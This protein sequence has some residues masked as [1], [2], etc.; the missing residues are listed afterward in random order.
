MNLNF[1]TNPDPN[2][3]E[4]MRFFA[5]YF[6][7]VNKYL[8][9]LPN[10]PFDNPYS[11]LDKIIFQ[12]ENNPKYFQNYIGNYFQQFFSFHDTK[13][14]KPE[15]SVI[16][17]LHRQYNLL[18]YKKKK[19]WVNDNSDFIDEIKRLHFEYKTKLFDENFSSLFSFINCSHTLI[20]HISEIKFSVQILV[21]Q[22]RLNGYSKQ[23]VD[24]SIDRILSRDNFPF[25]PHIV[26]IKN[27]SQQKKAQKE[28][29]EKRNFKEQF[30][31]LKNLLTRPQ[32]QNGIFIYAIENCSLDSEINDSFKIIFD[33]VTFISPTHNLLK[34][35]NQSILKNPNSLTE[36]INKFFFGKNILLAYI[37]LNYDV[38]KYAE[39]IGLKVVKQELRQFNNYLN[40]DLKVNTKHFLFTNHLNKLEAANISL[41]DG[42]KHIRENDVRILESNPYETLRD[43]LS[44]AKSQ[45]LYNEDIF[46]RAIETDDV[47]FYWHYIENT[48]WSINITDPLKI[49]EEFSKLLFKQIGKLKKEVLSAMNSLIIPPFGFDYKEIGLEEDD[50][51]IPAGG[52]LKRMNPNFNIL[53]FEHKIK[54]PFLSYLITYHKEF[55]SIDRNKSWN[56]YFKSLVLE[57][58]EYRNNKVHSGKV[59]LFAEI[60]LREALPLVMNKVRWDLINACKANPNLSF[61]E[62]IDL[63]TQ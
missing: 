1:L 30:F 16:E 3:Q 28:Y 46:F 21:S 9:K 6:L 52:L 58:Y 48:F 23:H 37:R 14:S 10:I 27:T 8:G 25:P 55:D 17:K 51:F 26:N 13:E 63:L 41:M 40:A 4:K 43:I 11:L 56:D 39:E 36:K 7:F 45:I 2:R 19:Q 18:P 34:K 32:T 54:S 61:K 59:N 57:L 31:G 53:L 29:L 22:F 38:L 33:Q 47:T 20:E 49:Q 42:V 60:K 62:L 24:S 35:L 50:L 15:I 12:I 5:D 44:E